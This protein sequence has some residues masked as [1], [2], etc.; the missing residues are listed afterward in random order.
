MATYHVLG[1][2]GQ[3]T[4]ATINLAENVE[5]G[6]HVA[7]KCFNTDFAHGI[8]CDALREISLLKD[9]VHPNVVKFM[10]VNMNVLEMRLE[11]VLELLDM[12][13]RSYIRLRGPFTESAS[14]RQSFQQCLR[15]V[16]FCHRR[17]VMHRDIKPQNFLVQTMSGQIKLGDFGLSRSVRMLGPQ[18]FTHEVITL[19]YRPPEILLGAE[20]YSFSVD[21]WSLGC[22]FAEMATGRPQFAG[23][24]EIDQIFQIFRTLG[25]PTE[26]TWPGVTSLPDFGSRCPQWCNTHFAKL[27]EQADAVAAEAAGRPYETGVSSLWMKGPEL[28]Q[29]ML[30]YD[31]KARPT[32]G[33]LLSHAFFQVQKFLPELWLLALK[34]SFGAER[35]SLK[36]A[37]HWGQ[38]MIL[39]SVNYA[40]PR[41]SAEMVL[42]TVLSYL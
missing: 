21:V 26:E 29:S 22:V 15:A 11:L 39:P 16:D 19:W 35:S 12:D 8:P 34:G 3:G 36:A 27:L 41:S 42:K 4:Y 24:S 38:A 32:A 40:Q 18:R 10:G 7:L 5:S 17:A 6:E 13:L 2:I 20:N 9:L 31:P 28:F 14:V 23:D 33:K 1:R 37:C 30:S 25:T